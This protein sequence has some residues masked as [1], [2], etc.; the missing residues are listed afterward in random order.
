MG[1]L[2]AT[3]QRTRSAETQ[4][5]SVPSGALGRGPHTTLQ[6]V[7]SVE[8]IESIVQVVNKLR[9]AAVEESW[10]VKLAE[11]DEFCQR[12]ATAMTAKDFKL[13]VHEYCLAM[14]YMVSEVRR[15]RA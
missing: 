15:H 4:S 12:A 11:F 7:P 5:V 9:E 1:A 2:V 13:A 14:S 10:Q 6:C 3:V 8:S